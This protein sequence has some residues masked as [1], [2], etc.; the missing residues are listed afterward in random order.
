MNRQFN[1]QGYDII[2]FFLPNIYGLKSVSVTAGGTG[3]TNGTHGC[4]FTGGGGEGAYGEVTVSSGAVS[5]VT[6]LGAGEGYTSDPTVEWSDTS[7]GSGATFSFTKRTEADSISKWTEEFAQQGTCLYLPGVGRILLATSTADSSA[8]ST[9]DLAPCQGHSVIS[10]TSPTLDM[11]FNNRIVPVDTDTAGAVIDFQVGDDVFTAGFRCIIQ[12]IT[13]THDVSFTRS[14]STAL[15]NG[16]STKNFVIP[17]DH[18]H[19]LVTCG[20]DN[21]LSIS[22]SDA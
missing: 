17:A 11:S 5:S 19:L 12:V 7:G 20:E 10:S 22:K 13:S 9:V 18:S 16:G 21:K 2:P 1:R 15:I 4:R 3:Y 14:G 6:V 8:A